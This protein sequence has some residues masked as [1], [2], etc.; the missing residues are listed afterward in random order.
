MLFEHIS[1]IYTIRYAAFSYS[2]FM[3]DMCP[4][5]RLKNDIHAM[6]CRDREDG[7]SDGRARAEKNKRENDG[8]KGVKTGEEIIVLEAQ[9]YS[10]LLYEELIIK[11]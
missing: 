2:S 6:W 8:Q 10:S 4:C 11:P 3:L 7:L 1:L 9:I 5:S